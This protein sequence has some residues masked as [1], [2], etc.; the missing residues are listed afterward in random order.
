MS[1]SYQHYRLCLLGQDLKE[2]LEELVQNDML[3]KEH[4]ETVWE[5]FER[6]IAQALSEQVKNKATIKGVIDH[7]RNHDDIW[8]IFLKSID[9]KLD[10]KGTSSS[11]KTELIAVAKR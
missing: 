11:A 9:I 8:T 6:A 2:T 3:S 7:Y 5:H 4:S 10:G 1:G